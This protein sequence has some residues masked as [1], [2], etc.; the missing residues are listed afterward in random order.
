MS[1]TKHY[2]FLV[3][4]PA[5]HTADLD[6]L[7]K[8]DAEWETESEFLL[9]CCGEP[10]IVRMRMEISGEKDS[11][12]V[13]VWG[14][15]R[16]AQLVEPSRGYE[17]AQPHLTDEQLAEHGFRL[18]PDPDESPE[19]AAIKLRGK[20]TFTVEDGR[21]KYALVC[22]GCGATWLPHDIRPDHGHCGDD[23][24][25]CEPRYVEVTGLD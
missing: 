13:E 24:A 21:N 8:V 17:S 9:N 5:L 6:E 23:W 18:V 14:Y 11:E 16:Q 2:G 25:R 15:V 12:V 20:K 19:P 4:V 10:S 3:E 1:A 7:R 22:V